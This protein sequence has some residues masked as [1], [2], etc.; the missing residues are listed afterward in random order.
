MTPITTD[1]IARALGLSRDT[2]NQILGKAGLTDQD[3]RRPHDWNASKVTGLVIYRLL[4]DV[5]D[6]NGRDRQA[7]LRYFWSMSDELVEAKLTDDASY[8]LA[9]NRKAH[10]QLVPFA[11]VA[12]VDAARGEALRSLGMELKAIDVAPV[13]VGIK[14]QLARIRTEQGVVDGA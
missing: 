1:R 8:L 9:C 12:A 6:V 2:V 3:R 11:V 14:D 7:V 10:V 5:A 4:R 13:W